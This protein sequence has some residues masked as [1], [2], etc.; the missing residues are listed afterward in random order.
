[1]V[2]REAAAGANVTL[3]IGGAR[4]GKCRYAERLIESEPAPLIY[5]A[6]QPK[7]VPLAVSYFTSR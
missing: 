6:T 3:V 7:L 4:S 1:M 5:L 2:P